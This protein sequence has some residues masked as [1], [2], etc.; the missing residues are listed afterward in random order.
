MDTRVG[1]DNAGHLADLQREACVLEWLLHHPSAE[2]AEV[3]TLV[4]RAAI[5]PSRRTFS[6]IVR[7]QALH[8][9]AE[10]REGLF[11]ADCDLLAS[12]A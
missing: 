3:T 1:V 9:T 6:E 4:T 7:S 12:A 5:A 11:L 10:F 2:S 8:D